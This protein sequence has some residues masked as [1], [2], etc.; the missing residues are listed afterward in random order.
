[1]GKGIYTRGYLPHWDFEGSVQAVTFR[2]AD[3]VPGKLIEAWRKE[4]EIEV[5]ELARQKEIHRRIS[6]YEDAGHGESL[7]KRADCAIIVQ[8]KMIAGHASSYRLIDW[9]IMPNH[10]HVLLKLEND[11]TL[12]EILKSWKGS[13]GL[14]I[15]RVLGRTGTLWQ[16]E[17]HDR[18]VRDMDHFHNCRVYIRD[19]PVKAGLCR[20]PEEW[21]FSS[22]GCGWEG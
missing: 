13:G 17:Y 19:N 1:M 3:S 20:T 9:C 12:W 7:L 8:T 11:S 10:V 4:L 2:L 14:E 6:K 16:R 21:R 18:L 22:A 5:N 15:N